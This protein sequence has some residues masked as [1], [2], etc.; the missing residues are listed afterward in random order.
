MKNFFKDFVFIYIFLSLGLYILINLNDSIG[1][2]E[3]YGVLEENPCNNPQ[4]ITQLHMESVL[5][6]FIPSLFFSFFLSCSLFTYRGILN[7][8]YN[9]WRSAPIHVVAVSLLWVFL[10]NID[11]PIF[12]SESFNEIEISYILYPF[13][14]MAVSEICYLISWKKL[15]QHIKVCCRK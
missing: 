8:R 14:F 10:Y 7:R 3:W 2:V 11:Y 5:N 6:S 9:F 15:K 12:F 4:Y 13:F 1:C